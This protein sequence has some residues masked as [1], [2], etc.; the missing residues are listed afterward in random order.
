VVAKLF[1]LRRAS[2]PSTPE[3]EAADGLDDDAPDTE[4]VETEPQEPERL[5]ELDVTGL[6][7]AADTEAP[8]R[9]EAD[10]AAPCSR[11]ATEVAGPE[12]EDQAL[13]MESLLKALAPPAAD[14]EGP[15]EPDP[16][17]WWRLDTTGYLIPRDTFPNEPLAALARSATAGL[18]ALVAT[19]L[20]VDEYAEDVFSGRVSLIVR[21]DSSDDAW[22]VD[23]GWT[24]S[25][26]RVELLEGLSAM[27][28]EPA[29][30]VG[31]R[32][33]RTRGD[34]R[35]GIA[36]TPTL[37]LS[38]PSVGGPEPDWERV[39]ASVVPGARFDLDEGGISYRAVRI[40]GM[41]V[42]CAV[43]NDEALSRVDRW[44]ECLLAAAAD[45]S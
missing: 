40:H 45:V 31:L 5:Q 25:D 3:P 28:G 15:P 16:I 13:E 18:G 21:D 4:G 39:L 23:A 29:P 1:R 44:L 8:G 12:A 37:H 34:I 30:V 17:D 19:P 22:R 9:D 38:A 27:F 43:D 26:G 36:Q 6:L 24:D 7:V 35:S 20:S 11:P 2:A 41:A 32:R 14:H 33:L 42:A 10:P